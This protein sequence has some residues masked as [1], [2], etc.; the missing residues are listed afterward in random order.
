MP[1]DNSLE[2]KACQ[3]RRM[4]GSGS[5]VRAWLAL[6]YLVELTHHVLW[7]P[8]T[9]SRR[10]GSY[11]LCQKGLEMGPGSDLSG[12]RSTL[13]PPH[14]IHS[15]SCCHTFTHSYTLVLSL[16]YNIFTDTQ[17]Y[18]HTHTHLHAHTH[19][20]FHGYTLPFNFTLNFKLK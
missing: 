15:H 13:A 5:A 10:M 18:T 19:I 8:S 9:G 17:T 3:V 4:L 1:G 6:R 2:E 11:S 12:S 16:T 7:F 20:H 14:N